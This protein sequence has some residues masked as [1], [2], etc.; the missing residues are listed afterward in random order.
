MPAD[1]LLNN[2]YR[3]KRPLAEDGLGRLR[4]TTGLTG[5]RIAAL[6]QLFASLCHLMLTPVFDDDA[7]NTRQHPVA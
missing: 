7:E 6:D 4:L 2:R 5:H 1:T 3:V